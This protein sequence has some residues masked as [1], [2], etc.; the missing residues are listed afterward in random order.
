LDLDS[1]QYDSAAKRYRE[2]V[3]AGRFVYEGLFRLGQISERRNANDDAIELYTRVT[4]GDFAWRL[5][6][7]PPDL[8]AR[9]GSADDGLAVLQK[10]ADE[11]ED[12]AVEMIVA[13]ASFLADRNEGPR[14]L[15][16]VARRVGRV[17]RRQCTAG[18][19]SFCC[20]NA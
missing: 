4:E 18:F 16:N 11:H 19:A 1:G 14:A 10:F 17:S 3:V 2:L 20:S 5:R 8:K 13:Q 6:G 12:L 7:V 15:E 9:A